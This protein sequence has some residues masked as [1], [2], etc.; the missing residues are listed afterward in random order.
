VFNLQTIT[1]FTNVDS[2]YDIGSYC[3]TVI[4]KFERTVVLKPISKIRLG[5]ITEEVT[6][7]NVFPL[8]T[9]IDL[10]EMEA[11]TEEAKA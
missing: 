11:E 8:G 6:K 2:I 7:D 3:E 9:V 5:E 1:P 10:P 4:N